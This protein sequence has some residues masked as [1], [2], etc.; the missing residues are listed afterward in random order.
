[1]LNFSAFGKNKLNNGIF[2]KINIYKFVKSLDIKFLLLKK[3][4]FLFLKLVSKF[5]LNSNK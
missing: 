5:N 2:L 4:I 1:M 3:F